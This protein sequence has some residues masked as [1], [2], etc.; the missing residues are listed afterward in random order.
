MLPCRVAAGGHTAPQSH[1]TAAA[2]SM[3][4]GLGSP[5]PPRSPWP[6]ASMRLCQLPWG[7]VSGILSSVPSPL[8]SARGAGPCGGSSGHD[9][10]GD[11]SH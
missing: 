3:E 7:P 8:P 10:C 5:S 2:A 1:R 4:S 9:P 6:S 11:A